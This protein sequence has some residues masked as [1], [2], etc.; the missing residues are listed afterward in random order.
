MAKYLFIYFNLS[1]G[2]SGVSIFIVKGVMNIALSTCNFGNDCTYGHVQG[3]K[4]TQISTED[5]GLVHALGRDAGG[6]GQVRT[7]SNYA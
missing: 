6:T 2:G 4:L 5:G 7:R 1:R 3:L